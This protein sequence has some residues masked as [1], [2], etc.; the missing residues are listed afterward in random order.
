METSTDMSRDLS[1]IPS[2][3]ATQRNTYFATKYLQGDRTFYSLDVS[4][5]ELVAMIP[6]P[7]RRDPQ[8]A[9]DASMRVTRASS[10]TTF[11]AAEI[12]SARPCCFGHPKAS[13][14]LNLSGN[15]RERTW[16]SLNTEAGTNLLAD[17]GR[18]AQS[19]RVPSRLGQ[20]RR[21]H[22]EV[23]RARRSLEEDLR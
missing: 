3:P 4:V 12:G 19:P 17:H 14:L 15:R 10:P 2:Q 5:P 9:T 22:R 18:S 21:G 7:V 11:A 8:R 20:T 13:S 16:T 1:S 6:A 23:A